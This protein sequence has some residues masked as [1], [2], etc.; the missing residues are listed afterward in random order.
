MKAQLADK[1]EGYEQNVYKGMPYGLF[2][3]ANYDP[4]KSYPLIVYLH[5]SNDTIF[6]DNYWYKESV[7]SLNPSF[8]LTPKTTETIRGWGTTWNN[9]NDDAQKKALA[10]INLLIK[11]YGIDT[12]RLYIYGVD[13][14]ATGVFSV[15]CNYPGKFAAAVTVR[16]VVSLE[17]ED[18][19]LSTP[20]WIF[21]MDDGYIFPAILPSPIRI[22][23]KMVWMGSKKVKYTECMGIEDSR[24][25]D[26]F[27]EKELSKWL[28]SQEKE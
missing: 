1:Y 11:N 15:I 7:Q 25:E 14:G 18:K 23:S 5:G 3:P 20:L 19:L 6:R 28:F 21:Y 13:M 8:V 27:E 9:T 12:N 26:V 24:W 10:L 2:K 4:G 17:V 16:G 22:Y